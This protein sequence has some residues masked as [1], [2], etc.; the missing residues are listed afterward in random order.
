MKCTF[1]DFA[2]GK[3]TEHSNGLPF[4]VLR[5]T[6]RTLT[7]LSADQPD[8]PAGHLLVIPKKH[9]RYLE[10]VDVLTR[11][12]IMDGVVLMSQ[13]VRSIHPA[14]NILLNNGREAGQHEPHVHF[15]IIPRERRDHLVVDS[16]PGSILS[17]T[18]YKALHGQFVKLLSKNSE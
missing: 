15:H 11:H 7:F 9:S 1:C 13:L 18:D 8:E 16:V 12:E 6:E 4:L 5:E 3:N 2:S 17:N 10:D 14:S